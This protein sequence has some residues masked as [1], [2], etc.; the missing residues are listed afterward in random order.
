MLKIK[1]VNEYNDSGLKE[2]MF[3]SNLKVI[4]AKVDEMLS[5]DPKEVDDLLKE[6]AWAVDH[7]STSKDDIEEVANFLK[8]KN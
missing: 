4:K 3:F 7:I 1:S 6:H 2:Y 8:T 5:M